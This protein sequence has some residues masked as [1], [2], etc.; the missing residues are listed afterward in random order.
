MAKRK[1][2]TDYRLVK[3]IYEFSSEC[4]SRE[5]NAIT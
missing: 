1:F 5:Y 3:G 2:T 4:K